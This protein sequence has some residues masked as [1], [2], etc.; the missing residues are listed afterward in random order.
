M[1]Y[2]NQ[3]YDSLSH[4]QFISSNSINP[5]TRAIYDD[6]Y[7]SQEEYKEFFAKIGFTLTG[8]EGYFYFTRKESNAS[9]ESK[10]ITLS[11]WID[12][13]DFL[14]TYDTTFGFGTI[15]S[16]ASIEVSAA[17]TELK[18]KLKSIF[19]DKDTTRDKIDAIVGELVRQGWAEEIGTAEGK[20]QVT[21][22]FNYIESIVNILI[23]GEDD[24]PSEISE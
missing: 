22:A 14:K 24:E 1:N 21:M 19:T 2:I 23:D 8:G 5:Q 11:K 13:L 6:L 20:Y 17:D 10:L 9:V 7:E 4:G 3:V 15:F 12:I 18:D 16:K